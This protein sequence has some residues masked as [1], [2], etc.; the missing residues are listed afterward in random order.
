[1]RLKRENL[2][3][4]FCS[5]LLPAKIKTYTALYDAY[6]SDEFS[7]TRQQIV[8]VFIIITH[9]LVNKLVRSFV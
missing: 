2:L 7:V 1:M 5:D 4:A 6:Q 8:E 9:H 3:E